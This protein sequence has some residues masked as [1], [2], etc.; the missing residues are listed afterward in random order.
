M[1]ELCD[2]GM[3]PASVGLTSEVAVQWYHPLRE[4]LRVRAAFHLLKLG[5]N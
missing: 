2:R 4:G 5:V 1:N 3:C